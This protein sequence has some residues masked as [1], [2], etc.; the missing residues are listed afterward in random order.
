MFS[1]FIDY[2]KNR[3][4]EKTFMDLVSITE[5]VTEWKTSQISKHLSQIEKIISK[6]KK[7]QDLLHKNINTR[8]YDQL[9]FAK[10]YV[11]FNDVPEIGDI[12]RREESPVY[13]WTSSKKFAVSVSDYDN[14]HKKPR[15]GGIIASAKN[16]KTEDVLLDVY[17]LLNFIEEIFSEVDETDIKTFLKKVQG[18]DYDK[19]TVSSFL[20]SYH[21]L[22]DYAKKEQEVLVVGNA[23][24][25]KCSVVAFY[26]H[27]DGIFKEE[28]WQKFK[29][30]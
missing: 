17:N 29:E 12:L 18:T 30:I 15:S 22:E 6:N 4:E 7:L 23:K 14:G 16:I 21:K 10:K 24:N 3:F 8:N 11:N 25:N 9:Y 26:K 19:D 13:A 5:Q 1:Y 2:N 27:E 28:G 20:Y